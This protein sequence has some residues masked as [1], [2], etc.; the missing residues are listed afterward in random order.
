MP[1][2]FVQNGDLID[3][4]LLLLIDP[5]MSQTAC[6]GNERNT[7][8]LHEFSTR[9]WLEK[10]ERMVDCVHMIEMAMKCQNQLAIKAC[11]TLTLES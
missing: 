8:G 1:V 7:Y 11:S 9:I 10:Q 5:Y 4:L 6:F 2:S 3:L